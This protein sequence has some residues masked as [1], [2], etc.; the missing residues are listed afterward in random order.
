MSLFIRLALRNVFR[1]R[2]RTAI[3]LLAIAAGCAALMVNGGVIYNIFAELRE[4]AIRGRLGH[5]QVYRQGYSENHNLEP[6]RYLIP[7]EESERVI[8]LISEL[9]HV[10]RVTRRREFSGMVAVGDR[11]VAFVGIGV[12][13]QHESHFSRHATLLAGEPLAVEAPYGMI[14][15][16]G[17]AEKF[18]GEPGTLVTL[19][20][21]MAS[22]ALNVVDVEL[23]G[24]F[25]GG[26]KVYDDWTLKLPLP[27]VEELLMDDSTEQI[28]LMLDETDA[29]DQTRLELAALFE[30]EGLD[31]ELKSW[32]D[33]ALF[34]N[35]TVALFNRELDVIKLIVATIVILGI[36]N[37]IGMSIIERR[38]E[39]ATLRALGLR[40]RAIGALLLLEALATGLLGGLM[41]VV[42]GAVIAKVVTAIG[43]PFPSPPGATRPFMGG[44]DFDLGIASFAFLLSVAATLAAALLPVWRAT[45]RPISETLRGA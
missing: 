32:R 35:Q 42:L 34:H 30:R 43:I 6:D 24:I 19:M 18:A 37:T 44:V 26:M 22:G 39:L 33:L 2:V 16:L 1:N 11:Y 45:R 13:P 27:A 17:L 28:I 29:V 36:A 12:D 15:G 3:A 14:A 10:E 41:G 9:P 8:A 23:R 25:E 5:L 31:L 38:V 20:T 40:R 7:R 4:D 21:N